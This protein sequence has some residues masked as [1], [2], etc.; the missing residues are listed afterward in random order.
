[1]SIQQVP[2]DAQLRP[3]TIVAQD[4]GVT[5]ADGKPLMT[6]L[7]IPAERLAEGPWGYR[8]QVV[9]YDA[10][11]Q[12][13]LPALDPDQYEHHDGGR[14]SDPPGFVDPFANVPPEQLLDDPHFHA[15]NVYAIVMKTLSR[16]EFALGRRVSW[17]LRSHQLKV[18]P[19]AFAM[20]NAFYS[21]SDEGLFF[22][23]FRS[24]GRTVLT[25][26][27][28]DIVAHETT[29]ALLDGLRPRFMDLSS[30]DQA[31]FHEG[32]S[33][34]V[35]LLS[36]FA[37]KEIVRTVFEQKDN[38]SDLRTVD[39]RKFI[40]RES[41]QTEHLVKSVLLGL[42]EQMG[43]E[44]SGV[45]GEPLRASGRLEATPDH[46]LHDPE[47]EEPHRRGEILVAAVLRAFL[48]VF[49]QR[50]TGLSGASS[51]SDEPPDLIDL[52]R[53]V[54]EAATAADH[55][56][57]IAIRAIDYLMP[58]H[59][60][61]GDYLSA[62]LTADHEVCANDEKYHYRQQLID[63]FAAFGIR[64]TASGRGSE[65]GLWGRS[66]T[67]QLTYARSH[68]RSMQT[69]KDEVFRFLWENRRS[70]GL[71]ENIY[72]QILSV[73]PCMRVGPDGF[74]LQETVA[75]YV[76]LA[77][78]TSA[79][80]GRMNIASPPDLPPNTQVRLSAGGILIFDEF[81]RLKFHIA[82]RLNSVDRQQRRVDYLIKHGG[83]LHGKGHTKLTANFAE[84]H[85]LRAI[86]QPQFPEEEIA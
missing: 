36:V 2:S 83:Y 71:Y 57:T 60:S 59:I 61:F 17:Q 45:R 77:D 64:P 4:P 35:A 28:H 82:N 78:L 86:G 14:D 49:Q 29:H 10:A 40:K 68:F 31:A 39:G 69:D 23:Y 6:Q 76:Q 73:R 32:F 58:V 48:M 44:L 72:T 74:F 19:H 75:E 38:R 81:G 8:V 12:R 1:M 22:G 46:Y 13:F 9:D 43:Q 24:N 84:L 53:A 85:R 51:N 55:L 50:L 70:L 26:L 5:D 34:I 42:A 11:T 52:D 47:F 80:L 3:L 21:R 54:E 27:S 16:F 66:D 15:Q 37:Q 25:A 41:L 33:D 65:G 63:A 67:K 62:I 7:W 56:L 30:A 18:A 79:E 20:A